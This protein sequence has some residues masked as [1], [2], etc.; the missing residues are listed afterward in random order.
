MS[1]FW[2]SAVMTMTWNDKYNQVALVIHMLV[3]D[4]SNP[5]LESE[6]LDTS[7]TFFNILSI[8]LPTKNN[9]CW[10]LSIL[11]AL[12][13]CLFLQWLQHYANKIV[14]QWKD[15]S[16]HNCVA[17]HLFKT[18]IFSKSNAVN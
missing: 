1:D 5:M 4:F 2:T 13:K 10:R 15:L 7:Y 9:I 11:N 6:F 8:Y 16:I 18:W 3:Y 14:L 17:F 12:L